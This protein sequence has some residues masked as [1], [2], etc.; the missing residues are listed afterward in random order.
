MARPRARAGLLRVPR[1]R[2]RHRR[3]VARR[4]QAAAGPRPAERGQGVLRDGRWST[5]RRSR[6]RSSRRRSA[7]ARVEI[8]H[9]A[10]AIAAITS[11]TNTSNPCV[12][13]GAG[14]LAKKAVE[15]GLRAQAVGED[16]AGSR[17]EG[18]HGLLR[19]GRPHAV[20]RRPRTSTSSGTAAPPA[21]ATPGPLIPE[22]SRAVN[23]DDLAVISVLQWQPQLRGSH[24]PRR[25][26]ELPGHPAARGRLRSRGDDGHRPRRTTR[27]GTDTDGADV[28]LADIW[29]T[30][31]RGRGDVST[32]RSTPT[33]SPH[34]MPTSSPA[35]SAGSRCPTPERRHLRVGR[36]L[37]LRAQ[38]PV[39]RRHAGRALARSL[40]ITGARVLLKLGDS[41]TTDHIS[42]AGSHQGRQPGRAGTSP[43]TASTAPTSTPTARDVAT[44]RS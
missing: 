7:A 30:P 22:V 44:T 5:T 9:G 13:I 6:P 8:G 31:G 14:L 37:H 11:C 43:S 26:D 18:R 16:H 1:A 32:H 38:A 39:L 20:P 25:Q 3:A 12:M 19:E 15:K 34:G 4:A 35:T 17:L 2:P 41:V 27:S 42:P 40:D 28:F 23:E 24:Q 10:V 36:D 33:C 21:S 29:P